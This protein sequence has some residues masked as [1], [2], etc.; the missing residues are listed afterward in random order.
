M[1]ISE[2]IGGEIKTPGREP[3]TKSFDFFSGHLKSVIGNWLLT[4]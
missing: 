4:V 3:R 1:V 2:I